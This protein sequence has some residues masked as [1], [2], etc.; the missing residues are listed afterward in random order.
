[1]VDSLCTLHAV[2][3]CQSRLF[4]VDRLSFEFRAVLEG[5]VSI[6]V[7]YETYKARLLTLGSKSINWIWSRSFVRT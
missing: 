1:M 6:H 2:V 5:A 7:R 3:L 4:K